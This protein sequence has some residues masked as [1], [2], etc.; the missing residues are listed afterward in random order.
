[1]SGSSADN[2]APPQV[3]TR[4]VVDPG[5]TYV[6]LAVIGGMV[7]AVIAAYGY[8]ENMRAESRKGREEI[9]EEIRGVQR[10]TERLE[11]K[12]TDR[13]AGADMRLWVE[14]LKGRNPEIT[15]P[16]VE[17]ASQPGRPK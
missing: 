16:E 13:W 4:V 7:L 10:R 8:F 2:P 14:K 12:M 6:P 15:V 9:K 3:A 17:R 5:R 11:E 1:M